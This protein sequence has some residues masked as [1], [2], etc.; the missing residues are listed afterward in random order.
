MVL[1]LVLLPA[2]APML[3]AGVTAAPT[4]RSMASWS[5]LTLA[6]TLLAVA[7]FV[8]L[9]LVLGRRLFPGCSGRW[10]TGSRELFTLCVVA[11]GRDHRLRSAGCS[12]CRSRSAPSSPA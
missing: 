12:A 9:M 4:R 8:A 3:A 5:W 1:V 11:R 7:A 2:L 6:R 10:R